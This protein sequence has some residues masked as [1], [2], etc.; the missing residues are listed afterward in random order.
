M[1]DDTKEDGAS[2][3][4]KT[5]ALIQG[6][7]AADPKFIS[8]KF[9][10]MRIAVSNGFKKEDGTWDNSR[11]DSFFD[12][13]VNGEAQV[14]LLKQ[15]V[16]SGAAKKGGHAR[17]EGFPTREEYE[18]REKIAIVARKGQSAFN[19]DAPEPGKGKANDFTISGN[20]G[21]INKVEGEKNGRAYK[22]Y[23]VT[24]ADND[25][26]GKATWYNVA[27][28]APKAVAVMDAGIADGSIAAGAKIAVTGA[29][30][31]NAWEK[32]GQ[33]REKM[34]L[35]VKPFEDSLKVLFPAKGKEA[36]AKEEAAPEAAPETKGKK[37]SGKGKKAAGKVDDDEIP[38]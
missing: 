29:F 11:P 34:E 35:R 15:A 33:K 22:F 32:D 21:Q 8:D 12:V 17:A 1:S 26:D 25:K 6:R 19:F 36:A 31:P 14:G 23:N 16:E 9:A 20:I 38:F 28:S 5:N 27:V 24:I 18:G 13:K 3:F 4:P 30:E 2:K 10:T 37:A 7:L